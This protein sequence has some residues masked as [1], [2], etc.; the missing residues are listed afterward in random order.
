MDSLRSYLRQSIEFVLNPVNERFH[1]SKN[2]TGYLGTHLNRVLYILARAS[3]YLTFSRN[4]SVDCKVLIKWLLLLVM[5]T[6]R[7]KGGCSTLQDV[8]SSSD[9]SL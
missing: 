5:I 7:Y 3:S 2:G 9:A 8:G 6:T 4:W 1:E